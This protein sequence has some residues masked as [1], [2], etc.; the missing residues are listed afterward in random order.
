MEDC[1]H[2]DATTRFRVIEPVSKSAHTDTPDAAIENWTALRKQ[3][4]LIKGLSKGNRK[5]PRYLV[6]H[7][8]PMPLNSLA[9]I[10]F[11]SI[12]ELNF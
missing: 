10:S 11:R 3:R 9:K 1:E 8:I 12:K 2:P 6:A 7:V 5:F 4:Y